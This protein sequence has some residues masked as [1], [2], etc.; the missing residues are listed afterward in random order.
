[1]SRWHVQTNSHEET[2]MAERFYLESELGPGE[3]VLDGPEA[4]HLAAVCRLRPG[5]AVVLFNGDGQEYPATVVTVGKR[6]VTLDAGQPRRP[7][8]EVGHRI[9]AACP[10]PRGDRS[11]VVIEK[12][13]ELGATE[14]VP[15]QTAR[16]IIQPREAKL[17]KLQRYAI[18]ASKQCGR[19]VLMR[20]GPLVAWPDLL[21]D[22]TLP[23]RRVLGHP[24]GR[25]LTRPGEG[26]GDVLLA[27]GPEGGFTDDEVAMAREA[28][29]NVVAL[30]PRILR[31]ETALLALVIEVGLVLMEGG[32]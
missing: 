10:L 17:D 11:Q 8:R 32:S 2:H 1:M 6:Q 14:F 7:A 27:V 26:S 15:L 21:A 3:V 18:E 25:P 4:H 9:V 13:T 31:V 24:G 19:N 28:G 22:A 5:A 29:W 12:L 23:A 20:V 16:S 30:G